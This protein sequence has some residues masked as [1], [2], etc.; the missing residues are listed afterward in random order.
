M[1]TRILS[2]I[3]GIVLVLAI[4]FLGE[5]FPII[6][7][8]A[9]AVVTIII[10]KELL[11]AKGVIK[12]YKIS[13]PTLVFSFATVMLATT[14]FFLV[15]TYLFVIYM[16][17]IMILFQEEIT[18]TDLSFIFTTTSIVVFAMSCIVRLFK[19]FNFNYISLIIVI[20]LGIPWMADAGAYFIGT[21][22]GKTKLSPKISPNKTVEG[23]IGGIVIGTISSLLIGWIFQT[24]IYST[25][26]INYLILLIIGVVNSVLSI[27]GDLSFSLI[28]RSCHIKD[29]GNSIPGHGGF[30][31]RFDSVLFSAPLLL[32]ICT[33]IEV[34]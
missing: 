32:I 27:L 12:D 4:L 3:V 9:F 6:A 2:A 30:L 15:P 22:F 19:M 13:I 33:F 10:V 26:N 21:F 20:S 31:D 25:I 14:P 8:T 1:L 5:F 11:S 24:F 34:L 18:F 7:I 23:A 29:Y 16:F 17:F 28:K